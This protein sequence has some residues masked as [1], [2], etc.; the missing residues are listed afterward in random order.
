MLHSERQD[1][2]TWQG[3]LES[4]TCEDNSRDLDRSSMSKRFPDNLACKD[5]AEV[6]GKNKRV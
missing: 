1:T 6:Q 5:D 4:G 2:E 3:I